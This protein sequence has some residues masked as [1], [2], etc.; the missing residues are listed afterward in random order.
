MAPEVLLGVNDALTSC[1]VV[2]CCYASHRDRHAAR[3][4]WPGER[5]LHSAGANA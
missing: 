1:L 3:R 5:R 4:N 2:V